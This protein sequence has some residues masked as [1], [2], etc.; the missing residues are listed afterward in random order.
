MKRLVLA[1]NRLGLAVLPVCSGFGVGPPCAVTISDSWFVG[2][3]NETE[4]AANVTR[5]KPGISSL[6]SA[7]D[8]TNADLCYS[9]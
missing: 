2:S 8:G 1:D 7:H 4:C 5:S 9:R 3:L 6:P